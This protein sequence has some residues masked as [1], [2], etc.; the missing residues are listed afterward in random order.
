MKYIDFTIQSAIFT[1]GLGWIITMGITSN[2]DWLA[3]VLFLQMLLG[4]WQFTS[5]VIS[6]LARGPYFKAK[7]IHLVVSTI[8]LLSLWVMLDMNKKLIEIPGNIFQLFMIGPP[9]ILAIYYYRI[10][11]KWVLQKRT[12]GGKF[13]PH[14]NF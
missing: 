7:L 4:P 8:Y 5:S 2:T 9:W 13:L 1:L 12:G 11:W 3:G 14:I 10:T 6:V